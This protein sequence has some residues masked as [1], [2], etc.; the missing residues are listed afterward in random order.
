MLMPLLGRLMCPQVDLLDGPI[1][2]RV[3]AGDHLGGLVEV[4]GAAGLA[5]TPPSNFH[6]LRDRTCDWLGGPLLSSD[7]TCCVKDIS[8]FL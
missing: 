1:A 5:I 7:C 8:S 2:E 6:H 4:I 3:Q